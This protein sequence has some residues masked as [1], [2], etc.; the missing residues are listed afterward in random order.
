MGLDVKTYRQF[1][2]STYDIRGLG[3]PSRQDWYVVPVTQNRDSPAYEV[4][5]FRVALR[6][7]GGEAEGEVEVHR[8]GHWACGW[9]EILLVSPSAVKAEQ[10]A[11]E[12]ER[13]LENYPLLDEDDVAE[14]EEDSN[15]D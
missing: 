4:S 5:N 7:L 2:P 8:F 9:F 12:I 13:K 10:S 14:L 11:C 3:L 1:A 6:M 15:D